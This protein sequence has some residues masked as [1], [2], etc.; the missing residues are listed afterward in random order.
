MAGAA[1]L[2]G[3]GT[4]VTAVIAVTANAVR[5][6]KRRA[7][8]RGAA[9]SAMTRATTITSATLRAEVVVEETVRPM[10]FTPMEWTQIGMQILVLP[11]ISQGKLTS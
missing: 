3:R 8:G 5:S 6:A 10:L 9:K 4:T 1:A 7:M 2:L 11:S